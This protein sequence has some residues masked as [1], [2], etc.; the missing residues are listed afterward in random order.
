LIS[1]NDFWQDVP[2]KYNE[3]I[4]CYHLLPISLI[5]KAFAS[6]N[7]YFVV[8]GHKNMAFG[9]HKASGSVL[10]HFFAFDLTGP[11]IS[12]CSSIVN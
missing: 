10:T 5:Y 1:D 2:S 11:F 4:S 8:N 9:R 3:V 6:S 7:N 12:F